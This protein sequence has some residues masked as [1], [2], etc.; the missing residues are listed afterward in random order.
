MKLPRLRFRIA[1]HDALRRVQ[2]WQLAQ[3][4]RRR[5]EALKAAAAQALHR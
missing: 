4:E 1:W 3:I 2:I 5:A